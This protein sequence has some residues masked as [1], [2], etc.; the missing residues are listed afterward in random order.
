MLGVMMST[1]V[2]KRSGTR[3]P[4][5]QTREVLRASQQHKVALATVGASAPKLTAVN[6]RYKG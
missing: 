6:M 1:M 3:N 2:N 4:N 5:R